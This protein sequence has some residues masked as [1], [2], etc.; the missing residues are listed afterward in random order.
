[1]TAFIDGLMDRMTVQEKIRLL[2]L[3]PATMITMGAE[4]DSLLLMSLDVIHGYETV[5]LP[6][7][8][9]TVVQLGPSRHLAGCPHRRQGGYRLRDM[10][11]LII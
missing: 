1:M 6:H 10:L 5:F 11:R 8:P 9:G 3:L 7:P 4:K 2:N